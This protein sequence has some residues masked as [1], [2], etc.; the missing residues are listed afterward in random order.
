M[1]QRGTWQRSKSHP[2]NYQTP[3]A[4]PL[5]P[6]SE[7]TKNKLH[8]FQFQPVPKNILEQESIQ[9]D[10]E[11][12]VVAEAGIGDVAP[13]PGK[14]SPGA[15][16]KDDSNV[17]PVTRLSWRDLVEPNASAEDETNISPSERLLW[18]NKPDPAHAYAH[19]PMISRKDRKRARSSSPMS[20]PANDRLYPPAINVKK[21]AQAARS[22]HGDP[23]LEL[24]D[25]FSGAGAGHTTPMGITNPALA[26]LM[27]SSSPRPGN[28]GETLHGDGSLRRAISCG[29]QW[30]KRR[31]VERTDIPADINSLEEDVSKAAFVTALLDTVTSSLNDTTPV[32]KQKQVPES[33]SPRK[34]V[35]AA[36]LC[37]PSQREL[38]DSKE[39]NADAPA[40]AANLLAPAVSDY[41]DDDF[42]DDILM[43]LDTDLDSTTARNTVMPEYHVT[44]ITPHGVNSVDRYIDKDEFDDF[45]DDI[46]AAAEDII[47]NIDS[48]TIS[49]ASAPLVG[50]NKR[51]AMRV[52]E[53]AEKWEEDF[54]NEFGDD[55]VVNFE[56]E[57]VGLAATQAAN[58][59]THSITAVCGNT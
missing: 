40:V 5:V 24:W 44:D 4:K 47:A 37:S 17:T 53:T 23:T 15:V 45:D 38:Y 28:K 12:V 56:F 8:Q 49:Q 52:P 51:G 55:F 58:P 39:S 3:T 35:T 30:P 46:L 54:D 18:N 41:G 25:R 31:K 57:A 42:D 10:K 16:G 36:M 20:S 59:P 9:L 22:P 1:Q 34:R 50:E 26:Q 48:A 29:I 2:T 19:S 13:E 7:T 32:P 6:L 14:A 43:E 11:N 33:P 21:L 27:M